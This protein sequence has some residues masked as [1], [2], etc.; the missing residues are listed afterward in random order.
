MFV[1]QPLIETGGIVRK[2]PIIHTNQQLFQSDRIF[3]AASDFDEQCLRLDVDFI[4][5]TVDSVEVVLKFL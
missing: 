4:T 5:K 3:A 1:C 2:I